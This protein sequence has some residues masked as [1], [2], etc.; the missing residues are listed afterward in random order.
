MSDSGQS[1]LVRG[2]SALA[3]DPGRLLCRRKATPSWLVAMS[4]SGLRGNKDVFGAARRRVD[5]S[6]SIESEH[7]RSV[8][9]STGDLERMQESETERCGDF[10]ESSNAREGVRGKSLSVTGRILGVMALLGAAALVAP[11]AQ[12]QRVENSLLSGRIV[13]SGGSSGGSTFVFLTVP[14]T[15][16]FVLTQLCVSQE[17]PS[18]L[19]SVD[20]YPRVSASVIGAIAYA[21]VDTGYAGSV[22]H[23]QNFSPGIALSPGE[24]LTC[25]HPDAAD[26][27]IQMR[28]TATGVLSDR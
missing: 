26:S 22:G 5:C 25:L 6:Y 24:T 12:A 18:R 14:A 4:D 21:P 2:D 28:C 8:F 20:H 9:A 13:S 19:V 16:H 15:G 3:D 23:C 27:L 1:G 11:A 7:C 10:A 17:T